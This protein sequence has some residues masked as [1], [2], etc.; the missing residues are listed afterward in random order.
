MVFGEVWL[1]GRSR[2]GRGWVSSSSGISN[3]N[4]SINNNINISYTINA[5]QKGEK[6]GGERSN[7]VT[8]ESPFRGGHVDP[9]KTKVV[10]Q[11]A[12]LLEPLLAHLQQG[13]HQ[14]REKQRR[15]VTTPGGLADPQQL[16]RLFSHFSFLINNLGSWTFVCLCM[17]VCIFLFDTNIDTLL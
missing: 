3:S 16:L 4:M 8:D 5:L 15:T 17:Y 14:D 2:V 1:G 9:S 11:L 10:V 6:R 13:N 12:S 7:W